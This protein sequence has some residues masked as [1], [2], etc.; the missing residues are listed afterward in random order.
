MDSKLTGIEAGAEVNLTDSEVKTAYENN[1]NTNAY[2]DSE[3]SLVASAL[4]T[5]ADVD[6][7]GI[8][9]DTVDSYH[10]S[11]LAKLSVDNNYTGRQNFTDF[12]ENA[13]SI[14]SSG[15]VTINVSTGTYFYNTS[16]TGVIT[17]TFSGQASTGR[18][19]TFTL[20]IYGAG[21]NTPVW[22]GTVLWSG[23]V[24]PI[25]STGVDI[26]SFSTRDNGSTW[27]GFLAG[28]EMS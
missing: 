15:N 27:L 10:A 6:A 4:Q 24:V 11:Q 12:S 25:W 20:E 16:T 2:T 1:A 13:N 14:S 26:V 8:N 22:P 7:L 17:F 28:R 9:A 21:T 19:S 5:K 3:V 18:V 23:N